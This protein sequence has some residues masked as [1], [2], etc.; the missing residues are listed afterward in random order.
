MSEF[1]HTPEY[2]KFDLAA[3]DQHSIE[4]AQQA[5][6]AEQQRIAALPEYADA[7]LNKADEIERQFPSEGPLE[8]KVTDHLDMRAEDIAKVIDEGQPTDADRAFLTSYLGQPEGTTLVDLFATFRRRNTYVYIVH[9][10]A[11]DGMTVAEARAR[12]V[13]EDAELNKFFLDTAISDD[14]RGRGRGRMI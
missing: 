9:T 8:V 1:I 11:R 6:D 4:A 5:W 13:A 10:A 7:L 14:Y 2:P 3:L 12:S